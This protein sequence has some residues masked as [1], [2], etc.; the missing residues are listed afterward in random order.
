MDIMTTLCFHY[1]YK[2]NYHSQLVGKKMGKK[3]LLEH[4]QKVKR[5][6]VAYTNNFFFCTNYMFC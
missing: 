2:K 1:L 3:V 6:K 4:M 5:K